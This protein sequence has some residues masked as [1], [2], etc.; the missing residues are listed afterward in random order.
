MDILFESFDHR[1]VQ[2]ELDTYWVQ[3]GGCTPQDWIP[4][5]DGRMGVVHFKDY[6]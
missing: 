2:F 3:Q 1:Y 6:Y 5:V 4:K